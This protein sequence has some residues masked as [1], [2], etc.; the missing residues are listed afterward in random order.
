MRRSSRW[1]N[2]LAMPVGKPEHACY[3]PLRMPSWQCCQRAVVL[4]QK[5]LQLARRR[6]RTNSIAC[7]R[8]LH[9]NGRHYLQRCSHASHVLRLPCCICLIQMSVC[10]SCRLWAGACEAD[11]DVGGALPGL[12]CGAEPARQDHAHLCARH[13]ASGGCCH[14][15]DCPAQGVFTNQ[16]TIPLLVTMSAASTK[17]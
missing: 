13:C 10:Y 5:W 4:H 2:S 7:A 11:I 15:P 14:G 12:L 3:T 9:E 16:S 8:H 6:S 17:S 1:L